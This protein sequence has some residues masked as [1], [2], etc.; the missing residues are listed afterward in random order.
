MCILINCDARSDL[1]QH[2]ATVAH[3]YAHY[4]QTIST[5]PGTSGLFLLIGTIHAGIQRIESIDART[6]IPL[7]KWAKD[8]GCPPFV[9]DLVSFGEKRRRVFGQMAERDLDRYPPKINDTLP[10]YEKIPGNP[11]SW[12]IAVP[13]GRKSI[14]VKIGRIALME[15]MAVAAKSQ[16]LDSLDDIDRKLSAKQWHYVAAYTACRAAYPKG[17]AVAA[18]KVL[19]D[20][21]LCSPN[22]GETFVKGLR[23]LKERSPSSSSDL[24]AA[25]LDLF[26]QDCR[27]AISRCQGNVRCLLADLPAGHNAENPSWAYTTWKNVLSALDQRL[28]LPLSLAAPVYSKLN[29]YAL[30]ERVGSPV[31]L[32]NDMHLTLLY[33][34]P[35]GLV[36][37]A[38]FSVRLISYL[39][40]WIL[41]EGGPMSCP[42]A[43]CP[44]CP[45]Q[46]ASR[47]CGTD[48]RIVVSLSKA[49]PDCALSFAAKNLRM[50]DL[51]KR[52]IEY[53][54]DTPPN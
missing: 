28:D 27:T 10:V 54:E 29:L 17:N 36:R 33:D 31:I 19:C 43:G 4:V 20:I 50:T 30:A 34:E 32:T 18:T 5:I 23:L 45:P 1:S 47:H 13:D 42:Y 21:S 7:V 40:Q 8:P 46:R 11:S 15:G 53:S 14:G 44:V 25:A 49:V 35:S 9:R 12:H 22:R 26:E 39:C 3:E 52:T 41:F 51:I 24:E 6:L 38:I 48:A 2:A 16:V 37:H